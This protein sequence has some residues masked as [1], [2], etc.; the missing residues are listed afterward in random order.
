MATAYV[1]KR[2]TQRE[3]MKKIGIPCKNIS[4]G[5]ADSGAIEYLKEL[6]FHVESIPPYRKPETFEKVIGQMKLPALFGRVLGH[7][8]HGS[9]GIGYL[10]GVKM[11]YH[12][13]AYGPNQEIY[14]KD[15]SKYRVSGPVVVYL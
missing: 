2:V 13:P 6:G 7:G 15:F 11:Y 8:G 12:D 10:K 3:F 14:Y 4:I 1:G 9:V 5:K